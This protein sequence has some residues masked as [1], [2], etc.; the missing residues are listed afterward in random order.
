MRLPEFSVNRPVTTS[1]FFIGILMLGLISL[2][3]LPQE[4]FPSITY[5]QL[6]IVTTYENAAPE[7]VETLITK[8]VEE[9][10][11]TVSNLKRISSISKEGV[12]IV[13][14]E[15]G[16]GAN[17][18]FASLGVREK[19]DLIKERLPLGSADPIVMKFNPFELPVLTLS[20]TGNKTPA[21][22]LRLSRKFIKD[23]LEK[24]EG[25]ASCNV[26]GGLEREI[27]VAVDEGRLAAS[28][29][30]ITKIVDA[31][32]SSN[33][34]YPAGTIEEHFYEYLIRTM[35]EF[36]VVPEIR[37]TVVGKD[38][39]EEETPSNLQQRQATPKESRLI[40][41]KD[42]AQIKDTFQE[43][44]S[45]SRYNGKENISISVQKQAGTN[46]IRIAQKV[47]ERLDIIKRDL[48]GG[49]DANI[50]YDQSIFIKQ[51][52]RGVMDA[53]I[54]GGVLAF[55]VLFVFLRNVKAS[56]I[57]A[58]SMPISIMV[59]FSL[60]Y[61]NGITLNM[62]SLG[63]LALGIG[64]LVDNA[65]V[66]IENIYNQLQKK[67]DIKE[68]SKAGASEV[69]AS[70]FSSTLTTVAVFLPMVFVVGVAGQLFKELAFTVTFSLLA[71][72]IVALSLI[73]RLTAI[74]TRHTKKTQTNPSASSVFGLGP[75]Y[76]AII[77]KVLKLRWPFLIV[78]LVIFVMSLGLFF[79]I[80]KE[81]M[82]KIDQRE[83]IMKVT[84][85]S[86]TK[87]DVTNS[88]V[89]KIEKALFEMKEVEGAAV[90]IGS[91]KKK[92]YAQGLETMS[93]HQSQ[94]IVSLK[95]G[96]KWPSTSSVVGRLKVKLDRMNLEGA[97]I[98]FI[99]Q[100]SVFKTAMQGSAPIV[101]EI[102]GKDL[103]KIE[104]IS[105]N[106]KDRLSEIKGIYGIRTSLSQPSPETK[107][108][109]IKDKAALYNLSS[110][111]ISQ[112]AHTAIKGVVAT[113]FKEEGREIDIR[114]RLRKEGRSR[115]SQIRNILI[116][117]PL[118]IEVPLSEVAYIAQGLGPT[119]IRRLDQQRVVLVTANIK[120]RALNKVIMDVEAMIRGVEQNIIGNARNMSDAEKDI[121]IALSGESQQM[122]E[123]FDSLRFALL[124]SILLVYMIMAAQFESLW[125]PFVIMFT[126]PLSLMGVF[127]ALFLTNTPISVV[128]ML[129]VIILGGIVVNNGIILIDSINR[130][131][132]RGVELVEAVIESGKTR[133]RPIFMTTM[134]TVLGL[135][136]LAL[137][138]SEGSALQSPMA[139][140]VMGGLVVSTLL[141]LFVI[142][143]VYTIV[144]GIISERAKVAPVIKP[145]ST[146]PKV[147]PIL[148]PQVK[149]KKVIKLVPPPEPE[150]P[151]VPEKPVVS[152]LNSR[153]EQLL[154]HLKKTGKITRKEYAELFK[155]SV[156]TAARDLKEM[157]DKGF[158][159]AHG[160]LGPGRWYELKE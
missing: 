104:D 136:P 135:F 12:S 105:K 66:V 9:A 141:T 115:L 127:L 152:K 37:E 156:P 75:L 45:I 131:R 79:L 160:P 19:I 16:W 49:M 140:T 44:T 112:A 118:D 109:V 64:M 146:A 133:L 63:G 68:A 142:P 117:S 35:G 101:L 3:R 17:M 148:K 93:S 70:I 47:R 128:V 14:A 139:I 103:K 107:V 2:T 125:Q 1:M 150:P 10:V 147:E 50:I 151:A 145:V 31:L 41:L 69:A 144:A 48:P 106:I 111:V 60:M 87:L 96:R 110:G 24:V 25:V 116:H 8:I 7:E 6:T 15:F 34:N 158:L 38:K 59:A 155:V 76:S 57:V 27:L 23:E 126:V 18:D 97:N 88:V 138:L 122:A 58:G 11:G 73:P 71:S 124:L 94:I 99:L 82:P 54:Q 67:I 56:L 5:P 91:S 137:G 28:K 98:E 36:K 39:I 65:I 13:T 30:S 32:K 119:E 143:C 134:T 51:S 85:Q 81:F 113:R 121:D 29:I 132:S 74:R 154:E 90:S 61:F 62:L 46:T 153:Q 53:A 43:R 130:M 42:I 123:S 77:P 102:K 114:V 40:Y 149:E 100:E 108:N 86:G 55:L 92:D 95:K 72:L 4:L 22:L 159:T 83:F 26:S 33:L 89:E 20:I 78:V 157:L 52:I 84:M 129:G 120:D 80:D 21:E